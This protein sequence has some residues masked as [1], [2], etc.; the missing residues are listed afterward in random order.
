MVSTP[1]R[2]QMT[3][4]NTLGAES[5]V[6]KSNIIINGVNGDRIEGG[7][8]RGGNLFH[9]FSQF[10][11]NDDQRV[12]FANPSGV[13]NILTRVTG[14]Q[15]S[16]IFGTLGTEGSANLF[17]L[18]PNGIVFGS[19]ARLDIGGSFVATTA[20]AVRF[21]GIGNFSA[22]KPEVPPVL[23]INPDALLFNQISAG[24]I[25][26]NS[27]APSEL[28]P[29]SSFIARGLRVPDGKSLLLVGG[30]IQMDGGSLY[31]FGGRVE[32]GGLAG[33]GTVELKVD[34][35]NLSLNF[36]N[37]VERSDV[38]LSNGSVVDAIAGDGGSIAINARNLEMR[39][40]SGL[41]AGIARGI[42]SDSSQSGN[43]DIHATVA[44][45]LNN[46]SS[47]IN[48]VQPEAKGHGGNVN[49]RTSNLLVQGGSQIGAGTFGIG[50][51]GSLIVNAQDIQIIGT[52]GT[53]GRGSGL[54]SFSEQNSTGNAGSLT[55][56]TDSLL[57]KD[58]AVVSAAT[59]GAGKGGSLTIDAQNIQLI[60]IS[61]GLFAS[62]ELNSTGDAGS[63]TIKTD[64]LLVKDGAQISTGTLGAG[65]GGFL[66]IDAQDVQLSG[67]SGN[68]QFLSS[69]T[70]ASSSTGD[71]G[72]LTI[73]TDSLLVKDGAV[74]FTG[75]FGAGK[76]GSLTI[77]A[78]DVQLIG[79][80][81][82]RR[83]ASGLLTSSVSTG[84]AGSLTIK[85]DSLLINN[86]A[87]VSASTFGAG[88]GGSLTIDAQN[89]QL[90]DGDISATSQR[91]S[92]GD[93]G[94]L[95]IKTDSLLAKD[96]AQVSTGTFGAGKGGSLTIDAKN[97]QLIGTSTDGKFG[98]GLYASTIPNS[99]GDAGDLILKTESLLLL[100]GAQVLTATFGAG[101]GG[102]LTIDASN[103]VEVVGTSFNDILSSAIATSTNSS[104]DAGNVNLNARR[105]I[106]RDG[107]SLAAETSQT[108][109]G[110][111]GNL[112]I[113]VKD[114]VEV[115]GISNTNERLSSLSVRSRG[116][117]QAGNLTVNSPR[118]SVK[119][120]GEINAESFTADGGNIT[121][122]TDLLLLRRGGTVS[123]TAGINQGK[124]NGGNITINA[125]NGFI[126]AVAEENS[127]ISAN[128]FEGRGGNINIITNGIYGLQYRPSLTQ[129][130]DI[131]VSSQFGINGT[132]QINT[133]DIDPSGNLVELPVNLVDATQRVSTGCNRGGRQRKNSFTATGRGGLPPS[134]I[135]PLTEDSVLAQWVIPLSYVGTTEAVNRTSLEAS[136][137]ATTHLSTQ[138]VEASNWVIDRNGDIVLVA[139]APGTVLYNSTSLNASCSVF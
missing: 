13:E 16:N 69:L 100:D 133:P 130:S 60:G 94:S 22:T 138:I 19:N 1:I 34:G 127:D 84:D 45:N 2:A 64:S 44:I 96:G 12:Y 29:S 126:V 107:G 118:I 82:N 101:K 17:L 53:T 67:R 27:V 62:S 35:Q 104:G 15:V 95:T 8:R 113:N 122:N 115:T 125:N 105:L 21:G 103:I 54:F 41:Y 55:I 112:V 58:V 111:S 124:G 97:V 57:V 9:S 119:D 108:S 83:F 106:V 30:E 72:S 38:F 28:D 6:V 134:P 70:T 46:I 77:D 81:S 99:T 137:T 128:A 116:Q 25:V 65:K 110:S 139:G 33:V 114:A 3:P 59:F 71:A 61:S 42:G 120:R 131:N 49:I 136:G 135:E 117:G 75:T 85:T 90:I 40:R 68:P 109:T 78:K 48:A 102:S 10:N 37:G 129:L 31:A 24:A 47:I 88:K 32:L 87:E 5:S 132:V 11:I 86:G 43:I 123:A 121:L 39:S 23:T 26:N 89:I 74:I 18:N 4:D 50:K 92:T 98:S 63:L 76:G 7:A 51:G 14:G 36:P 52:G 93:A 66:I 80:S 79:T 73:K 91:N 56:K 20:N